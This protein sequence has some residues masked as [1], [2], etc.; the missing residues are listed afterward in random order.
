MKYKLC[1]HNANIHSKV[2]QWIEFW[3]LMDLRKFGEYWIQCQ[4]KCI[5]S[6]QPDRRVSHLSNKSPHCIVAVLWV[7][8]GIKVLFY[9][10][11]TYLVRVW[12]VTWLRHKWTFF[13]VR[14]K[15]RFWYRC[16]R[17]GIFEYEKYQR[18]FVK[19]VRI[20]DTNIIGHV[21][22]MHYSMINRW[23]RSY[24]KLSSMYMIQN[25]SRRPIFFFFIKFIQRKVRT[26][27]CHHNNAAIQDL[28]P[29]CDNRL[30]I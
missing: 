3:L 5:G 15:D 6:N 17:H 24:Q 21:N 14:L 25:I 29:C 26:N 1:T 20:N 19:G 28:I 2:G 27:G 13:Y 30:E 9:T 7:I 22:L 18:E 23:I 12:L 16:C 4:A 8:F 10:L 11:K